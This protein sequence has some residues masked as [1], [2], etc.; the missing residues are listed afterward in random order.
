MTLGVFAGLLWID[1]NDAWIAQ[2]S[3][4]ERLVFGLIAVSIFGFN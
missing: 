3:D 2:F 1:Q 4:G